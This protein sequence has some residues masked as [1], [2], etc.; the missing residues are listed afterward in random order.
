ML[1]NWQLQA[2]QDWALAAGIPVTATNI[3]RA[4]PSIAL[5]L[6]TEMILLLYLGACYFMAV[7]Q[8]LWAFYNLPQFVNSR[9]Y[10]KSQRVAYYKYYDNILFSA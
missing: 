1:L 5:N 9:S 8:L 3:S 6:Q 10:R 4:I 2:L 7:L